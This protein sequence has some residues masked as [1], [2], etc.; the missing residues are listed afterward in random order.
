MSAETL[1][2]ICMNDMSTNDPS[3]EKKNALYIHDCSLFGNSSNAI[4]WSSK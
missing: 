4:L 2:N 1:M 3:G